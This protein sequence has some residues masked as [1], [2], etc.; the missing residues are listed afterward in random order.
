MNRQ[1]PDGS[2]RGNSM[3][4]FT[5]VGIPI[6]FV[7]IGIFEIA[8]GMWAYHTLVFAVKEAAR[9]SIVH[10]QNCTTAPNACGVTLG[11]IASRFRDTGVGLAA[12]Q[13]NLTFTAVNGSINCRLDQCLAMTGVWPTAPGNA[14]GQD[15]QISAVYTF[16][17][18]VAMVWPGARTVGTFAAVNFPATA[19]E[20]IQF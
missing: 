8:R 17:S 11:Q 18:A 7:L 2:R 4:E 12:D 16:R 14:A 1:R 19:R 13:C 3:L 9:Y 6:L 20:P 10:G 15:I 5:L